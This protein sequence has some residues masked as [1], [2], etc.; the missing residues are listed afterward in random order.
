M[1]LWIPAIMNF[2]ILLL[3]T[4]LDVEKANRRLKAEIAVTA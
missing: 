3:L 1:Y 2:I 4:R